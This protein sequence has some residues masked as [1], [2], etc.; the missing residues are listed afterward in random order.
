ML[1]PADIGNAIRDAL[2]GFAGSA[3]YRVSTTF[4]VRVAALTAV[5]A[6]TINFNNV[7]AALT[8]TA[9]GDTFPVGATTHTVTNVITTAGGLLTGVTFTPALVTQAASATQVVISRAADHSVRVIMEQVDGYNL[10][11]GLYAGGDYRFTVFDLPVE[12]SGSGAHKVIWGGKTLTVQAEIS[13]D[14]TG[15]AWIVRAK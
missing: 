6:T 5:G 4:N 14:Q 9:I 1:T 3:V 15:A 8:A 12:P 11:G 2:G 7:P 13:R 10:I